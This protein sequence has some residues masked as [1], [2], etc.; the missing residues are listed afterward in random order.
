MKNRIQAVIFD[1]AGTTVDFGCFAPLEVFIKVFHSKGIDITLKE[2]REHMGMFKMDHIRAILDTKRIAGLWREIFG[3]PHTEEDVRA[4]Y[5]DFEPSLMNVLPDHADILDGVAETCD[6]L[7][8]EGIKI[9]S[10]TGYTAAMIKII[11]EIAGKNGYVPDALVTT[12]D[13]AGDGRPYPWMIFKNMEKL[14]VYPPHSVVKVG[15]T[16][17][18]ILEGL[19]AGVWSVGVIVGSSEM[20]LKR[21]EYEKLGKEE[22]KILNR[23]I[24][25]RFYDAGAHYVIKTISELPALIYKINRKFRKRD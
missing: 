18:D 10:T 7:R 24:E 23:K 14:M 21:E 3:K 22:K 9:G 1:W 20:S 17:C 25:G 13:V 19:N 2:A 16:R 15:D 8:G 6:D 5:E 11:S 4:L 12:E